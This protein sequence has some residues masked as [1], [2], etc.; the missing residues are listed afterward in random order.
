[1]DRNRIEELAARALKTGRYLY[2][3]FMG[4]GEFASF[5]DYA[6]DLKAAWR[7]EGGYEEAERGIICFGDELLTGYTEDAPIRL[8]SIKPRGGKF[9]E[10][11]THRDYL[12]ALMSL[13]ITREMLGDI[14]VTDGDGAD[15]KSASAKQEGTAAY[16]FAIDHMADYII[17]NLLSIKHTAVDVASVDK[18]P[19]G[20]GTTKEEMRI[21]VSSNRLDA[22]VASVFKLSREIASGL[23]NEGKVFI[24]GRTA[25]K[26]EKSLLSGDRVS[27]RG[28]G[29]FCFGEEN[30]VTKK[31][32]CSM[33]VFIYK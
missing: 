16:V 28:Y 23:V 24:N 1:M 2:T 29:K 20:I 13:G 3:D 15:G 6:D 10:K 26:K 32:R 17:E 12:G 27:V 9:A 14:I 7:I 22:V 18:L 21:T 19:E 33:T 8:I 5:L 31:G 11:L 25:V 30:G 4:Q